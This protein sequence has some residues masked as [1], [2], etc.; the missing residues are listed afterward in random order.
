MFKEKPAFFYT[1]F[2]F[3][4]IKNVLNY[5]EKLIGIR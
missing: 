3:Q 5:V 1:W 4:L 2:F